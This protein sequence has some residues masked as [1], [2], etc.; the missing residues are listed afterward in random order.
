MESDDQEICIINYPQ[1]K[2]HAGKL[3]L[4]FVLLKIIYT[5]FDVN[6]EKYENLYKLADE[7][8]IIA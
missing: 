2:F 3:I 5:Y 1:K 4:N 7:S 6:L 8:I